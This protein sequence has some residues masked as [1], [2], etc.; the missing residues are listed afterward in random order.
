MTVTRAQ[1]GTVLS[2]LL[3]DGQHNTRNSK[4]WYA[5]HL[6]TLHEAGIINDISD[7]SAVEHR[8]YIMLMLMRAVDIAVQQNNNTNISIPGGS[9][10]DS[11][12][13]GVKALFH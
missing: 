2:R 10:L 11:I 7:P 13:Q 12:L 3:Y 4:L 1:F 8:G 6:L 5:Q 9:F